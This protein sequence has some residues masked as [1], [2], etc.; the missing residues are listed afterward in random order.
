MARG[1]GAEAARL[2]GA[3]EAWRRRR[4]R[5]ANRLERADA[6]RAE[7]AARV[8]LGDNNFDE[9]YRAGMARPEALLDDA[10]QVPAGR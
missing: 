9:A 5:P 3:A 7:L 4:H 10:G 2:L 8:V 1:D 6:E